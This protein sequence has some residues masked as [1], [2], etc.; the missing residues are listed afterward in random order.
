MFGKVRRL[1]SQIFKFDSILLFKLLFY[2]FFSKITKKTNRRGSRQFERSKFFHCY[3]TVDEK[4]II[5]SLAGFPSFRIYYMRVAFGLHQVRDFA[6][7]WIIY[8]PPNVLL[9]Y[10]EKFNFTSC[11]DD[12]IIRLWRPSTYIVYGSSVP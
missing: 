4:R 9:Y 12:I 1:G 11:N 5:Y 6:Q 10:G 7:I 2:I 8:K 3:I